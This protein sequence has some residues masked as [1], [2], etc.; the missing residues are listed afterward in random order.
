MSRDE[1]PAK[2]VLDPAQFDEEGSEVGGPD[3]ALGTGV[4]AGL[5]GGDAESGDEGR[6]SNQPRPDGD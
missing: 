1:E 2:E 6:A 3:S 5:T 4:E